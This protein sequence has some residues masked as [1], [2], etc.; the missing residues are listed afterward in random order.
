MWHVDAE[1]IALLFMTVIIIDVIA[2]SMSR[3]LKDQMFRM[4]SFV[5]YL[6]IAIDI[7]SSAAMMEIDRFSWWAI[8]GSLL[9]YFI[10]TP[11]LSVLWHLYAISVVNKASKKLYRIFFASAIPFLL[12]LPL[13]ASNPVTG[14]I[15]GLSPA[16]VYVRGPLFNLLFVL[17]YGYGLATLL[18]AL[19]K[20]KTIERTTAVILTIF[21]LIAGAGVLL[22]QLWPGYLVTGSA[23]TLV[24]LITYLFLQNRKRTRDSLTGLYNRL[25][26][27]DAVDRLSKREERGFVM[28]VALDDFKLFNQT[29]G[30]GTGDE[31]LKEIGESLVSLSPVKTCYRYGG[32]IFTLILRK[33]TAQEV[34][35]LAADILR[36]LKQFSTA[37]NVGCTVSACLG[38]VEYPCVSDNKSHSIVSALDFAI[39]QA[40]K[41]GKGQIAFYDEEL[42]GQ[43]QRKRDLAEALERA[44][45]EKS[46]EVYLQPIYHMKRRAFTYGEALLRLRDPVLGPISPAEFIPIAEETGKIVEITYLVLETVCAFLNDH[47]DTLRDEI[48]VSVNFS[49]VQFMQRDMTQ[50]VLEILDR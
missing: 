39:Y 49:M 1:I 15:F 18:Y 10:F 24:L 7:Y 38:I 8:E 13:V 30:Q 3:T 34:N 48:A 33:R 50:R 44:I 45:A 47:R 20:F 26:F 21:P 32:D 11:M 29:F 43:L 27:S 5:T 2:T 41:R 37:A 9:L 28:A 19:M 25:A 42:I 16:K 35:A 40:K 31:L 17:F 6:A 46:F 12:Y 4:L 22:Q 14:L 36:Q 23:F